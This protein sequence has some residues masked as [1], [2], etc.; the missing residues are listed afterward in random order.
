MTDNAQMELIKDVLDNNC[1]EK[2]HKIQK[3]TP[4]VE[5]Y[6]TKDARLGM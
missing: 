1:F 6:L 2:H 5:T 4:A 3:K